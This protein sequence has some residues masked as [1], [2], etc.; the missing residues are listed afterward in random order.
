[1]ASCRHAY[2]EAR[3][4]V[5]ALPQSSPHWSRNGICNSHRLSTWAYISVLEY[6]VSLKAIE[7][8]V[9]PK[10]GP[11]FVKHLLSRTRNQPLG[12]HIRFFDYVVSLRAI[13][14]PKKTRI[15]PKFVRHL[16]RRTHNQPLRVL[17]KMFKCLRSTVERLLSSRSFALD[18]YYTS[19]VP[20][21]A[22]VQCIRAGQRFRRMGVHLYLANRFEK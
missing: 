17:S 3:I 20:R 4:S 9:S 22:L 15:G 21:N 8:K 2:H 11:K 1:M 14:P 10:R 7:P 16:L 6:I 5:P 13:E 12:A 19:L 18:L